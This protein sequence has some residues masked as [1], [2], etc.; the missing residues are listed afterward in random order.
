MFFIV[1]SS[2][3]KARCGLEGS[4]GDRWVPWGAPQAIG[5][6]PQES[7]GG[8]GEAGKLKVRIFG[9]VITWGVLGAPWGAL[10]MAQ[11]AMSIIDLDP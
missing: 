9:V 1:F 3:G 6:A 8:S 2:I 7:P 11:K 4:L 10:G 5:E